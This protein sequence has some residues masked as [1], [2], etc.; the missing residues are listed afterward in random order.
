MKFL[1]SRLSVIIALLFVVGCSEEDLTV[2]SPQDFT[3]LA[4]E[5]SNINLNFAFPDNPAFTLT[6]TDNVTNSSNYN[7]EMA[8]DGDFTAPVALGSSSTN[9]F[10]MSV[11]N[12]NNALI[13]AGINAYENT[14]VFMRVLAGSMVSN[15]V[16]FSVNSYPETPPVI[17]GPNSG[18][19]IVLSDATPDDNAVT[20][21]WED[22]DFNA[23]PT[24]TLVSVNYD[25]E[26]SLAGT[27][28]ASVVSLGT[29]SD[30]TSLA[31]THSDLNSAAAAAGLAP[32]EVGSLDVRIKAT[33]VTASGNIERYSDSITIS[34]TPYSTS[35]GLSTWGVV[36]SGY[37]NWGAFAD[38][39]FYTTQ[40]PNVV[41]AYVTLVTGEIKFRE[42]N[43]WG[44]NLGDDGANGTL[45][46]NG[47]NIPVTAGTYKITINFNDNTYTMEQW[48]LGV[49]GSGYN[50]WGS[51]GPDAKFYY[52]YTTDT[53][54]V[55]VQLLDGEIKFRVNND[56]GTNYGGSGGSLSLNG[57]NIASSAGYYTITVDL[58][59][60]TY[61]IVTDD[62]L[63]VVG[64]GYNDWGGA[65]PD[66]SLTEANPDI[67]VG[68]IVTLID[69]E[70]KFRVNNDWTTN[71]GGTGGALSIN[72]SNIA[73][74]A[75]LYRVRIDLSNNTYQLNQVQ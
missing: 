21:E 14:S 42:N 40:Q 36:G 18:F 65:G 41:V 58:N 71:Y 70:I 46:P 60:N 43:D 19:S 52:D 48:S 23:D 67:W 26:A 11:A 27:D 29:T 45:E 3:L 74:S 47:A 5:A 55:G 6:W 28:F 20:V 68:D 25:V 12:F 63:G 15:S 8:T 35:A 66:F 49:V 9:T 10:T 50:D 53:F 38:G 44:N 62:I 73:V 61:T 30:A 17:T 13:S 37:N 32:E 7:V 56:W 34:V 24:N 22:P 39:Q 57:A 33:I 1:I 54:K 16:V 4:P 64:S 59:N 72:G 2:T 75:G 51:A 69:G 31:V